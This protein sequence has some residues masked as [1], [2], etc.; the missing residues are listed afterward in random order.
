MR[1]VCHNGPFSRSSS[2]MWLFVLYLY[3]ELKV[4]VLEKEKLGNLGKNPRCKERINNNR[5]HSWH[6]FE[7]RTQA[8]VIRR[9]HSTVIS[10]L[11]SRKWNFYILCT[12]EPFWNLNQ[13]ERAPMLRGVHSG[14]YGWSAKVYRY[15]LLIE[16]EV[17]T[18]G[19]RPSFST[20]I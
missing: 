5:T 7:N 16:F 12:R 2:K 19:L 1:G 20:R 3:N 6:Q 4:S 17:R 8:P 11:H 18:L 15:V 10:P 13:S 14:A 9:A